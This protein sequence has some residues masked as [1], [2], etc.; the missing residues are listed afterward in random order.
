MLFC[1]VSN[2]LLYKSLK[3]SQVFLF[4]TICCLTFILILFALNIAVD[5]LVP[6]F[7]ILKVP[8]SNLDPET[9]F[10]EEFL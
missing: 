5:V 9:S 6:F 8:F 4:L 10:Y 3:Q 7:C 1:K 2:L